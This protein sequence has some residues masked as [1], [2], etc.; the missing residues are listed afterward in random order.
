MEDVCGEKILWIARKLVLE[1]EA[2]QV[3]HHLAFHEPQQRRA[4]QF[5]HDVIAFESDPSAKDVV[6][7][8]FLQLLHFAPLIV[9]AIAPFPRPPQPSRFPMLASPRIHAVA[10]HIHTIAGHE[11][12]L[13]R[14]VR[15]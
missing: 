5:Q 6:H 14:S 10:A 15:I 11:I 7:D 12:I 13:K 3:I 8:D 9:P 1:Q 4:D 2:H